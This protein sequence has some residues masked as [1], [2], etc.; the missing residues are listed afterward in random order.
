MDVTV[1]PNEEFLR[2]VFETYGKILDVVVRDYQTYPVS[3]SY[4]VILYGISNAF[5]LH[6][7]RADKKDM[8]SLH[9]STS[10]LPSSPLKKG[11]QESH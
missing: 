5:F 3:M 8:D 2:G 9:S 4:V 1:E 7:L 10:P 11:K 6:R